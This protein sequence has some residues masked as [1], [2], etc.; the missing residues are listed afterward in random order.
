M[1]YCVLHILKIFSFFRLRP[2]HCSITYF[3]PVLWPDFS[4]WQLLLGVFFFQRQQSQLERLL[5]ADKVELATDFRE[6]SQCNAPSRSLLGP[7]AC[8]K[9]LLV[10][11]KLEEM[12]VK[13]EALLGALSPSQ[14]KISRS[15]VDS[16]MTRARWRTRISP[17]G[18]WSRGV[19]WPRFSR[20]SPSHS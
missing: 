20:L 4:L 11:S 5:C 18:R 3:S 19:R 7:F 6:V 10:L 14:R 1:Y 2:L 9:N 15:L 12:G 8:W 16:S 17:G 13:D